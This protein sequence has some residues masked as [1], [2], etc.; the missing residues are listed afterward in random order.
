ML[1][2]CPGIVKLSY[3]VSSVKQKL[4]KGQ[5]IGLLTARA[6]GSCSVRQVKSAH[7]CFK[8]TV[9]CCLIAQLVCVAVVSCESRFRV[10]RS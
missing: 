4:R 10:R 9:Q 6:L 5:D 1:S 2:T 7:L 8:L 3:R